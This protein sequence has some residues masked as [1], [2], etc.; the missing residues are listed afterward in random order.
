MAASQH[1]R[2]GK[3]ALVEPPGLA[4]NGIRLEVDTF[5]AAG[6]GELT[7]LGRSIGVFVDKLERPCPGRPRGEQKVEPS[8]P[9][10]APPPGAVR[11]L[12]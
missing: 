8:D 12:R 9:K 6:D 10:H 7:H 11:T 4:E 3:E 5:D 1:D 2:A